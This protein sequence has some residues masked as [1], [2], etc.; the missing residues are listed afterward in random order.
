MHVVTG[1]GTDGTA[2][3][4]EVMTSKENF[5]IVVP[6]QSSATL[7]PGLMGLL[8][9]ALSLFLDLAVLVI[10]VL[11]ALLVIRRRARSG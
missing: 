5:V 9:T 7:L 1:S 3:Y 11:A 4:I 10:L 6:L 8:S 2:G